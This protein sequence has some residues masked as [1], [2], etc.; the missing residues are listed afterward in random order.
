[1]LLPTKGYG[2]FRTLTALEV[3]ILPR[4]HLSKGKVWDLMQNVS[5]SIDILV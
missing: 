3:R 2:S 1:M 4:K 5:L